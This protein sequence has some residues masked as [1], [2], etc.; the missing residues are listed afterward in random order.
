MKKI[1]VIPDLK[2]LD[3][4]IRV[5]KEYNAGFEYNDFMFARFL[6][7]EEYCKKTLDIYKDY[8][9]PSYTT[10]HGAFIDVLPYS[11]DKKVKEISI[12]RINQSIEVTRKIGAKAVVMAVID[13]DNSILPLER[14]DMKLDMFP[15]GQQATKIIPNAIIGVIQWFKAIQVRNVTNGR[16]THCN[17]MPRIT[18][19]GFL[20]IS[21]NV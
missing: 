21:L 13:T 3:D 14:E 8:K 18:D 2:N 4:S 5:A 17:N 16:P 15:P 10:N 7:D 12:H 20:K 19:L 9:L 6:D 1:L 11:T